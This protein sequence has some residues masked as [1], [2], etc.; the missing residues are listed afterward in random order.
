[1][2]LATVSPADEFQ[3]ASI[4]NEV[5]SIG[6]RQFVMAMDATDPTAMAAFA[7]RVLDEFGR[8]DL[9]VASSWIESEAP[10][11]ELSADEWMPVVTANL[12]VPF[13]FVEALSKEMGRQAE[14]ALAI[15]APRRNGADAAE[16]AARAALAS[17][18]EDAKVALEGDGLMLQLFDGEPV[19]ALSL[20]G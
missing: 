9:A 7:A 5:W 12:T 19:G 4:A 13:L 11:A 1:M 15:V 14:G 6:T 3:V 18:V 17:L 2:A 10:F 8:C 16:R 20:L